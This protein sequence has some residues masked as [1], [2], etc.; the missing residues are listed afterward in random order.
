ML[1]FGALP[2][3]EQLVVFICIF[4][5]LGASLNLVMGYGGLFSISHAV[6]FGIGAYAAAYAEIHWHLNFVL[7]FA[8]AMLVTG[9]AGA[10]TAFPAIRLR[11]DY[12]IVA[13]LAT[14]MVGFTLF[15]NL[16][17]V[18]NG[19]AGVRRIP[20]PAFGAFNLEDS[21]AYALFCLC[22][23]VLL[24]VQMRMWVRSPW[25]RLLTAIRDD[26]IGAASLGKHVS[27]VKVTA[28]GVSAAI[29]ALA[30]ALYADF[31]TY[32]NPDSF[33]L[34][35][36]VVI[37]AVLIIG[38]LGNLYGCLIGATAVIVLPEI[39]RLLPL[40]FSIQETLDQLVYGLLLVLFMVFRPGGI[41]STGQ[42]PRAAF[43]VAEGGQPPAVMAEGSRTRPP[44][45]GPPPLVVDGISK[46]FGGI[47][48]LN[49]VSFE[50]PRAKVLGLIG[51][52][53]AGKTT[54]LDAITGF[55]R[56]DEGSITFEQQTLIGKRPYEIA[57]Q[58]VV[59]LFQEARVFPQMTLRE[60][61]LVG[62]AGQ[63]RERMSRY[64]DLR[65]SIRRGERELREEAGLL[66]DRVG[67][68]AKAGDPAGALSYGQQ[69]L[70]CL[71]RALAADPQLLLLDEPCV[72]LALPMI[73]VLEAF[74]DSL[75]AEGR[76]VV[77]IEHNVE[78]VR[79]VADSVVFM[80]EGRVDAVGTPGDVLADERLGRV[81]F[82]L[83]V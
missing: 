26:D 9:L 77:V 18:T 52:N 47:L 79:R 37:L 32:I 66:L 83:S 78:F 40:P 60:N 55:V 76:T 75:V 43:S 2:Y 10:I 46:R 7:A 70:L 48:A 24:L 33:T 25:G 68:K 62:F 29:A 71:V 58:G 54:M 3:V 27:A 82:G 65:L 72:G 1:D 39:L 16:D 15:V 6:F 17:S 34:D 8:F 81:Y 49:R 74:I 12:L 28:F 50:V 23:V 51:P 53:G 67:L 30:G 63:P 42:R 64:L 22:L 14:Q 19:P 31:V 59:R 44:V 45:V 41:L 4:A 56:P 36:S 11:G 73:R 61:V 38:G 13:S 5:M 80:H 35:R 69:K 57:R 21:G 20:F